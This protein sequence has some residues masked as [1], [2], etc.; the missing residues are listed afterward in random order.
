MHLLINQLLDENNPNLEYIRDLKVTDCCDASNT[1]YSYTRRFNALN[2]PALEQILGNLKNLKSFSWHAN[3][4]IPESVIAKLEE[5][6]PDVHLYVTNNRRCDMASEKSIDIRLLSS[7]LLHSLD[8]S[9]FFHWTGHAFVSDFFTLRNI[10]S[11]SSRLRHLRLGIYTTPTP[12]G[13]ENRQFSILPT[14]ALP[15]TQP[16][17]NLKSLKLSEN[18]FRNVVHQYSIRL[19]IMTSVL[20]H[21]CS[22]FSNKIDLELHGL[23]PRFTIANL[24]ILSPNLS[25]LDFPLKT[26]TDYGQNHLANG[27]GNPLLAREAISSIPAL[28]EIA[29]S[30]YDRNFDVLWPTIAAHRGSLRLLRICSTVPMDVHQTARNSILP[31]RTQCFLSATQLQELKNGVLEH[32]EIDISFDEARAAW[33]YT[34]PSSQHPVSPPEYR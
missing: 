24:Q 17:P 11:R 28:D 26:S 14:E 10:I 23:S 30:N 7:P 20:L 12:A 18:P 5:R 15:I 34:F 33:V 19:E 8:Y 29:L 3:W 1:F 22:N 21:S 32:L 13:T 27:S 25:K 6:W 9:V 16:L 2:A 31:Q 4:N